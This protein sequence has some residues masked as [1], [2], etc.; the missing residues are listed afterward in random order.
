MDRNETFVAK[1]LDK[2]GIKYL[3]YSQRE[4]SMDEL[5]RIIEVAIRKW[6]AKYNYLFSSREIEDLAQMIRDEM[7]WV[8]V[9][10]GVLD[11]C[12]ICGNRKLLQKYDRGEDAYN[13]TPEWVGFICDLSVVIKK[14]TEEE[15]DWW[16]VSTALSGVLMLE[17][18][19]CGASGTIEN[20]SSQEWADGYYA[21]SNPYQWRDNDRVIILKQKGWK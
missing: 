4:T 5:K 19:S 11:D 6:L 10:V 15:H 14:E 8:R 12:P 20:P 17:C 21:P 18:R 16:V 1:A 13:E 9:R 2:L 7:D 3:F